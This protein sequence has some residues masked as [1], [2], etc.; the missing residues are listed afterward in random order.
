[1]NILFLHRNFPAQFV[2]LATTLL[3]A[4]HLRVVAITAAD[5]V[6]ETPIP[7]LRY[8]YADTAAGQPTRLVRHMAQSAARGQAAAQAMVQLREDGFHPDV[9]LGHVGWGETLFVRTVWP[10][11]RVVALADFYYT[12]TGGDVGFDPEFNL[13]AGPE[14]SFFL[15]MLN[16]SADLAMAD[17]DRVVT[18]SPWQKSRFPP[19]LRPTVQILHEGIDTDRLAPRSTQPFAVDGRML[20]EADEIVTFV[21]RDLE[22]YRGFHSFMRALP[23][24]LARRPQAQAV[25][26]GGTGVSYGFPPPGGTSWKETILGE[27]GSRLPLDRVHFTGRIPYEDLVALLRLTTAHVYLTYP[28]IL[29]WSMLEAMSLGALVIGSQTGPVEDVIEH[30]RNGL[31][32]DFFDT[33]ALAESIVEA[34]ANRDRFTPLRRAARESIVSGFDLRRIWLPQWIALVEDLTGQAVRAKR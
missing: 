25:I 5:N 20:S 19:S 34:L 6:R 1:M 2:H 13:P 27:V 15:R 8:P 14:R 18:A 3:D 31:L 33:D 28:F 26:V 30:G 24:V 11:A 9:V 16:A 32:V 21:S 22:P 23:A 4:P 10:K 17:A 7:T 12:E 29:S